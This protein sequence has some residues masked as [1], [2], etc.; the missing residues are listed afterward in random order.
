MVDV[1]YQIMTI[2]CWY[3]QVLMHVQRCRVA[4][5]QKGMGVLGSPHWTHAVGRWQWQW[6]LAMAVTDDAQYK[7]KIASDLAMPRLLG[8]EKAFVY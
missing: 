8:S 3:H 2:L 4:A 5:H 6:Q 1:I 7:M